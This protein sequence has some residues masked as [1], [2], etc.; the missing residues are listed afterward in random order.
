MGALMCVVMLVVFVWQLLVQAQE[1]AVREVTTHIWLH[2]HASMSCCKKASR[3]SGWRVAHE[4][5]TR[6][7]SHMAKTVQDLANFK[8]SIG[9]S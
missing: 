3:K 7:H 2:T 9:M 4:L 5:M 8:S 6:W 1:T